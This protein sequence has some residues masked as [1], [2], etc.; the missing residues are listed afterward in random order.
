M[1]ARWRHGHLKMHVAPSIAYTSHFHAE[2]AQ[3]ENGPEADSNRRPT[4]YQSD[5]L[6]DY[7]TAPFGDRCG[8]SSSI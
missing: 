7:A 8:Q 3:R 6:T 2:N 5:A 4:G 1:A